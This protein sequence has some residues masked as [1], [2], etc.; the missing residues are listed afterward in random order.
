MHIFISDFTLKQEQ[1]ILKTE[2][3]LYWTMRAL[4][5]NYVVPYHSDTNGIEV[6]YNVTRSKYCVALH[7]FQWA[8]HP[9]R[10]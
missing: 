6:Q 8:A 7:M 3:G 1:E 5:G 10:T 2:L 9:L 4:Q